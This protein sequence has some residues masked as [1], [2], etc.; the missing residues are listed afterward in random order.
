[1]M[2]PAGQYSNVVNSY[3]NYRG[4]EAGGG[5]QPLILDIEDIYNQFNYGEYSPLAI[6]QLTKYLYD[7][8]NPEHL[9]IIGK[10]LLINTSANI[11]DQ[12]EYYRKSS[13]LFS[14]KDLIPT[15]GIPGSD[16]TFSL[17]LSGEEGEV[18]IPTGRITTTDPIQVADYLDKVI[19]H[20]SQ[21]NDNLWKKRILHLSGGN[22]ATE[23]TR[24]KGYVDEF[25]N[26]AE[27]HFLGGKVTS[28]KKQTSAIN[29]FINVT[30]EI[31]GGLGLVT[32]YGHSAPNITDIDIGFVSD[33]VHDYDNK[34]RYSLI[35]VNGC[36]AG[37]IY[38]TVYQWGEDWV[39]TPDKGAI[40]FIAHSYFGLESS[41]ANYSNRF[42]EKAFGD[43]LLID[44]PIGVIQQATIKSY[45]AQHGVSVHSQTITQQMVLEGDPAVVVFGAGKV[46]YVTDN[47]SVFLQENNGQKINALADSFTIGIIAENTG[48]TD[49]E[50]LNV[51]VRRRLEDNSVI[52]YD[53]VFAPVFYRDTLYV[54]I[55]ND[56]LGIE[57]RNIF[58]IELDY[59]NITDE[60]NENNNAAVIETTLLSN[61]T[62]NLLPAD[63]AIVS[64]QNVQ[65]IVQS[66]NLLSNLDNRSYDVELDT[67][68]TFDSAFKNSMTILG[69]GLTSSDVTL[70][71]TDSLTY[72]WRTKFTNPKSGESD[73]WQISSFTYIENGTYGWL[74]SHR[75]QFD[76][77]QFSGLVHDAV[78]D[79]FSFENI[80]A[81]ISITTFGANHPTENYEAVAL[82][83]DNQPFI[84]T[85]RFCRDNTIN[86]V[87]FNK[88]TTTPYAPIPSLF[89]IQQTCGRADQVINNFT[90]AEISG[91]EEY[92]KT[93]IDA[94]GEGDIVLIF[95]IGDIEFNNW[96]TG[97]KSQLER[98]GGLSST[99]SS[100]EAGAP[101]ILL[102]RKGDTPGS[103]ME[104]ITVLSPADEQ[105]IS[106]NETILGVQAQGEMSS[107]II[108]P[109]G[110]WN[111][112]FDQLNGTDS[113]FNFEISGV[114][115]SGNETIVSSTA[116]KELLLADINADQYPYLKLVYQLD[117]PNDLTPTHLQYWGVSY[118]P[119]PEGVLILENRVD[120]II[121]EEGEVVK[122][123]FQFIN[124][125]T[126]SYP[127]DLQVRY[128]SLNK[129]TRV[130]EEDILSIDP[131]APGDTTFFS[132]SWDTIGK[133]GGNDLEVVVNPRILP[134]Q[135]Y[136]NNQVELFEYLKVN[137]D[138]TAPVV[139][140]VFDGAHIVN[141]GIV[142]A[143]PS[144]EIMIYD[145]NESIFITDTLGVEV[146]MRAACETCNF[147][148]L[149]FD[150]DSVA[151]SAANIDEQFK[152]LYTPSVLTDSVYTLRVIA[153][154]ASG[155]KPDDKPYEIS[156]TTD[157]ISSVG[158]FHPY[159]NPSSDE[160]NF[161]FE[162][163]GSYAPE[164]LSI[165]IYNIMGELVITLTSD[166]L[167]VGI[168]KMKYL[169]SDL[170]IP[171]PN[172][173]YIYQINVLSTGEPLRLKN[174]LSNGKGR[175]FLHR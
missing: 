46:D 140:V 90:F 83:I 5:Y 143:T 87:A 106:V 146:Y 107:M 130:L 118:T 131:P 132:I 102:G 67:V 24:F 128:A 9:F 21:P 10:G 38:S 159:P 98:V 157:A 66:S 19:A 50:D 134:E 92:L 7:L 52:N 149:T 111:N 110:S 136:D 122:Q 3:A 147:E 6:Y 37:Q 48:R 45:L 158:F 34:D 69:E 73:D 77:N 85:S 68:S 173:V 23:Q 2:K 22:T 53:T 108:G 137:P 165:D 13:S 167:R 138:R 29:E 14:T 163:R 162:I 113:D 58:D 47:N 71:S 126:V 39:F 40:G 141:G 28:L 63:F 133:V 109:S 55:K 91:G 145:N 175:L 101:Y 49:K 154:D 82:E 88:L 166:Q 112:F 105:T 172:G 174:S 30:D 171:I 51:R 123:D 11:G 80:T 150:S 152:I 8:G 142:A 120:N 155:N 41:L 79:E 59:V 168:N 25:K 117:D 96:D 16:L 17:G 125:S 93:T 135:Y 169:W 148:R 104:I 20:E 62:K 144:I 12:K 95:S 56:V 75:Q 18:A 33:P 139:D 99:I 78:N 43:S 115:H 119:V 36:N 103:A 64:D 31:N 60:L 4:T 32:F 153:A 127:N 164:E 1:M 57:G 86:I 100:L 76:K 81:D 84:Y 170:N 89:Q 124:V 121:V 97:L 160:I 129:D 35:L 26:T 151:W 94:I 156:F 161:V 65:L 116:N 42:Y 15:A 44:K 72:Y 27:T 70:L 114:D 74:Q 54:T 61:G